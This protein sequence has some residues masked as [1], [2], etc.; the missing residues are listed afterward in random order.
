MAD[1]R[2]SPG[3]RAIVRILLVLAFAI[4]I[5]GVLISGVSLITDTLIQNTIEDIT[6]PDALE[7]TTTTSNTTAATALTPLQTHETATDA[8]PSADRLTLNRIHSSVK[9]SGADASGTPTLL[10]VPIERLR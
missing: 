5:L 2:P 3:L 4:L 1:I 7:N 6:D 9:S 8:R 10:P